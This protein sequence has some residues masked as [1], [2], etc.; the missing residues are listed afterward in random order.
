MFRV[1]SQP[2][3]AGLVATIQLK[4]NGVANSAIRLAT[5]VR[6][7]EVMEALTRT[8]PFLHRSLVKR[9]HMRQVPRLHFLIDHSIAEGARM[10]HRL[11][12]I[13]QSEGREL[14]GAPSAPSAPSASPVSPAPADD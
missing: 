1:C 5:A 10:T 13:A 11:R 12:E 14:S 6:E 7:A 2:A 4:L 9:L 8:A 3:V